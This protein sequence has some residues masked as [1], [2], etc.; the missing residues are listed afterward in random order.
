MSIGGSNVIVQ[1]PSGFGSEPAP[2][3]IKYH[4]IIGSAQQ[5]KGGSQIAK[6][7]LA[8]GAVVAFM[9]CTSGGMGQAWMECWSLLYRC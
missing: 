6:V 8:D 9:D 7:A 3:L 2:L 5:W 4:P 1:F